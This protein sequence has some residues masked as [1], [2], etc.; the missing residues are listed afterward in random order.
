[1]RACRRWWDPWRRSTWLVALVVVGRGSGDGFF[2]FVVGGGLVGR[3]LFA[4]QCRLGGAR[5]DQPGELLAGQ[6]VDRHPAPDDE[7]AVLVAADPERR[8]RAVVEVA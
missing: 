7:R 1:R 8:E 3:R 5:V 2:L 6:A 4:D